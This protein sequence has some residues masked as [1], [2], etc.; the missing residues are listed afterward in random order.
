MKH[1]R[2][3]LCI[4][5]LASLAGCDSPNNTP[6]TPTPAG[7]VQL[8]PTPTI[9]TLQ[10]DNANNTPGSPNPPRLTVAEPSPTVVGYIDLLTPTVASSDA[11]TA[12]MVTE[13][14]GTAIAGVEATSTP[15][16]NG[17]S[18]FAGIDGI[19]VL[20]LTGV[21]VNGEFWLAYSTGSRRLDEITQKHFVIAFQRTG[22]S[23]RE[24]SRIDLDKPDYLSEGSIMQADIEPSH[25][26]ITVESGVGAHG[27]CFDLLSFDGK[28]F[29]NQVSGCASSPGAGLVEDLDGDGKGEVVL[30]AT[31]NYVFCY[32]CGVKRISYNVLHW[33]G[34]KLQSLQA[35]N[36]SGSE[37]A[38]VKQ[39]ND[40]AVELYKHELMKDALAKIE[41]VATLASTDASVK[42][43]Q[44]LIKLHADARQAHI[45]ES[46]YPLLA[47]M[48]YGDYPAAVDVLRG[49][50]AEQVMMRADVSPLV[51]GTTAE[52]NAELLVSYITS[53]T[54]L[55]LEAEPDLAGAY[56][57]RGWACY[58][59]GDKDAEALADLQ[60]AASL[61]PNDALF[62]DSLA[63]L[64]R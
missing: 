3:L 56:F 8:I 15:D 20:R 13:L 19:G 40:R 26:W 27:G 2:L 6:F 39:I 64:N 29:K 52:G 23:W 21:P 50:G 63:K 36:L 18:P 22:D 44:V 55:A 24:V 61:D 62:K 35:R 48:F 1:L 12:T 57:L 59:M 47:D 42:W 38:D 37:P 10:D 4:I 34:T 11:V 58:L 9:P 53:T 17:M 28:A 25:A 5:V 43:N 46:G 60:K 54:S 33:D 49:Y 30:D 45:K 31:D 32:A 41:E 14:Q 7:V 51:V 16:A